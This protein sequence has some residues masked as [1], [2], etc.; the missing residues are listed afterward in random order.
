LEGLTNWCRP[1][2]QAADGRADGRR[3]GE[4]HRDGS[5]RR[6]QR[7]AG[8]TSPSR[9]GPI[10]MPGI[11]SVSIGVGGTRLATERTAA[12]SAPA[13]TTPSAPTRPRCC[14][15]PGALWRCLRMRAPEGLSV[16]GELSSSASH[17][18]KF[19]RSIS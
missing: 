19:L 8:L 18:H 17:L 3:Q 13:A 7:T 9:A 14:A 12:H 2:R 15:P 4:G 16:P 5:R 10:S 11:L 1:R 6:S